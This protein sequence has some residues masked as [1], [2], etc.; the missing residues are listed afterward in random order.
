MK[1]LK[2]FL[3]SVRVF[4][5]NV[6]QHPH[7]KFMATLLVVQINRVLLMKEKVLRELKGVLQTSYGLLPSSHIS[8]ALFT[9]KQK[10][11]RKI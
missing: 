9:I 4:G 6:K 11:K 2:I 5:K 7:T 1:V 3:K 10:K 8:D